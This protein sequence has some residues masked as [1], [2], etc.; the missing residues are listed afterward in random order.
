MRSIGQ[1]VE[2]GVTKDGIIEEAQPLVDA[3]VAGEHETIPAV[4]FDNELVQVLALLSGQPTKS[5]VIDDEK[6]WCQEHAERLLE[7]VV[8]P[9]LGKLLQEHVSAPEEHVEAGAHGGRSQAL[10]QHGL[11]DADRSDEKD[12][13]V[14][15]QE[16]Q[17][18]EGLDLAAIDL[19]GCIPIEAVEYDAILE[20]G[21]LQVTFESLVIATLDLI[22][23]QQRQERGVIELLRT[24]QRQ[25][26]R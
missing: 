15:T 3:T 14:L 26:F 17:A 18:E 24:R 12:V 8:N 23:Q 11:A 1:T 19:D 5:K 2:R 13:L 4:A 6:V 16:V 21:L 22:G 7:G 25:A 20:A 9:C 10:G